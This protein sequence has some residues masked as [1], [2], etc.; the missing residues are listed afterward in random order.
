MCLAIPG[1]LLTVDREGDLAMGKVDFGGT[2]RRVCLE[3]VPEARP[4]DYVLVHV[5][6]ALSR[7][8][9]AEAKR[10]FELLEEMGELAE[11]AS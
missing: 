1:K 6:F 10:I 9:E 4:G 7:V 5:G 11:L 2:A 3:H 8:D